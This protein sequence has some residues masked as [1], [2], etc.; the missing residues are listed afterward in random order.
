MLASDQFR[1]FLAL[2]INT[3]ENK[4]LAVDYYRKGVAAMGKENWGLAVEMFD[5]C[6]HHSPG[7]EG[8]QRLLA[9]CR[10]RSTA[11]PASPSV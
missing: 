10:E 6:V 11:P 8:Y 9:K 2:G 7:V 3:M 5:Q 1:D 4:Q